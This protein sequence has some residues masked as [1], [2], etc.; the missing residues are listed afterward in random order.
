MWSWNNIQDP[1]ERREYLK[2]KINEFETNSP[3]KN[4]RNLYRGTNEFKK[5]A[6][7]EH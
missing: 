3:N 2:D 5:F 6:V 1:P 4:V 7:L